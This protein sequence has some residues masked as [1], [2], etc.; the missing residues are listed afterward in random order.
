MSQSVQTHT[1]SNKRPTATP[2]RIEED[3][4]MHTDSEPA[5]STTIVRVSSSTTTRLMNCYRQIIRLIQNK[6]ERSAASVII[7]HQNAAFYNQR[8]NREHG[9]CSRKVDQQFSQ[10]PEASVK[11]GSV[12]VQ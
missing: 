8:A 12:L 5:V 6:H 7:S 4:K 1:A 11:R 2:D 10:I 3:Q 9:A